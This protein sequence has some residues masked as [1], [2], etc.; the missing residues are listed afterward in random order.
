MLYVKHRNTDKNNSAKLYKS[1][2]IRFSSYPRER[3]P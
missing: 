3:I 1:E 2:N